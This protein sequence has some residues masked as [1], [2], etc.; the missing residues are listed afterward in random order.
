MLRRSESVP[1]A[2]ATHELCL[3][4]DMHLPT[5]AT[6]LGAYKISTTAVGFST[7]AAAAAVAAATLLNCCYM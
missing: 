5:T 3:V 7:A 2:V 4:Y 1:S 6:R